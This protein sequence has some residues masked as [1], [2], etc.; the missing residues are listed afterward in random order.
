MGSNTETTVF[1]VE[2]KHP[3][4]GWIRLQSRYRTKALAREWYSFI[5]AVWHGLPLRTVTEWP[6]PSKPSLNSV[7]QRLAHVEDPKALN[8]KRKEPA[9][10]NRS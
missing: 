4:K 5:K 6:I 3:L 9:N 2:V 1:A 7:S 10:A 8:G